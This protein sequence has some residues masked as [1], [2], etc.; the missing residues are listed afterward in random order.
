MTEDA[1]AASVH[2]AF[3]HGEPID[4]AVLVSV[5]EDLERGALRVASVD[6]DEGRVVVHEWVKEAI[7]LSFGHWPLVESEAGPLTWVDR[8][9]LRRDLAEARVRAVP[10]AIV[11]RG[12]YLGAGVTLMPSFVNVGASVGESTMVDTWATVGSCAQIGARVHLS[13][14]VGIG[15]VLEPPQ[16]AP[17]VVGD[18]AF[19]GSRAIVVEG[20][21]VGRGAVVAAGAVVTPTIPIIDVAT[22]DELERGRVPDWSVVVPGTRERRWPGGTFGLAALLVIARLPEGERHEK[23]A[24]NDLLRAH[25]GAL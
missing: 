25:G 18:D 13:G 19:V 8:I 1:R 6:W 21:I 15:G 16:A 12:T 24:L 5:F 3:A 14:G 17:V 10:G 2:G 7:L 11:R 22:G 23:A 20:S 4:T 9:P